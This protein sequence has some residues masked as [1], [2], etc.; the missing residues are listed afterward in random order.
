[1]LRNNSQIN[2]RAIFLLFLVYFLFQLPATAA[3]VPTGFTVSQ[4]A[5]GMTSVT[6]M[7]L[8]PDGRILVCEQSGKLRVIENGVLRSTPYLTIDADS[9]SEHG[10]LGITLDPGFETNQFFY[11]YYTAKTPNIHNR[12]SRFTAGA[13][14]ADPASE[15]VIFDID[16]STGPL[17]WHQGGNIGFGSDGKLYI[18]VG[19]DRNGANSQSFT[20]LFGKILRINKDGSIPSDNPFFATATGNYRAIWALGLRNPYTFAFNKFG[21]MFIN[22]VGEETWEEI[23]GGVRGGNYGWPE[24][25][26]V[27]SDQRFITPLLAYAHGFESNEVGCAITGGTFYEPSILQFPQEYSG[28]YFYADF[29]MGWIRTVRPNESGSQLFATF[30]YFPVDLKVAKNGTLY[31]LERGLDSSNT[32]GAVFKIEFTSQKAPVITQQPVNV[33]VAAGQTASFSVQASG[34]APLSYRWQRNGINLDGPSSDTPTL[35]ITAQLTDNGASYACV[36]TNQFGSVT[37]QAAQLTVVKG[38]AP[39]G[40][41]ALPVTGTQYRGGDVIQYSGTGTDADEGNLPASAFTW[42]VDFHHDTHTHPFIPAFSGTTSGQFTIPTSG[43]T[44]TDVWYRIHLTVKDSSGLTHTVFRDILPVVETV[45]LATNPAG[46]QIKLDDQPQATPKTISTVVG[47]TRTISAVSPQLLNGQLYEFDSWSDG[48]AATHTINHGGTF[49]ANFKPVVVSD[50]EVVLYASEGTRVGNYQVVSDATAAGG[51]RLHNPDAGAAKLSNAL[52]NPGTYVEMQFKAKAGVAYRLWI[53]GQ[54]QNNDPFSDSV[55]VQFNDSLDEQGTAKSR[56][57]TTGSEVINL[58]DCFGCGLNGW[59]WQDNGWGVG[60][61]GPL[62]YFSTSGT[63]TVRIQ[64][65]EDGLSLDQVVLSPE[66]YLNIAP[67]ALVNDTTILPKRSGSDGGPPPPPPPSGTDVVLYASEATR[68]G[69]YEVVNDATAAG[70]ARLH[71]P[72]TGAAKLSNAL[73]S[74]G[75]FVEMQFTA[76]AGVGYRLWIRGK[77]QNDDPFNDS[78]FVQFND[79]VDSQGGAKSRIGTTSSEVINLEDCFACGLSGWGWQDNGWGVGELGPLVFFATSGTHTLRIQPREDGLSLDQIVLSP[80][81]FVSTSPGAVVND[82]TILPKS[83]SGGPPPAPGDVVLYASEG[84]R[85][86]NYQVVSDATAAGGSRLH[87]PDGGAGKLSNALANPGTFVEM[88]FTAQAGVA[89]RLWIRGKAQNDD[90][91]NDSVFVQFNDSVDENG[92]A[93]SRIG[94]TSSEVINLEDCFACGLGGWGWQDNGWGVGELGPLVYFAAT[95]THTLRIQVR[96]DGLSI[97][98]IVLSP[99]TYLTTA[100]GAVTNDTTILTKT[101]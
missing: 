89:Y 93:K 88:Q 87:N 6:R 64:P 25:E 53:R 78:I 91:F 32:E 55:F 34:S 16:P 41:I 28:A 44:A 96:E 23:N 5:T 97:D 75:T 37:S 92:V 69:N 39:V 33:T 65:R 30:T 60:V 20:S 46:L 49:T 80:T 36:V 17:G 24:T 47:V 29:C 21:S 18:A 76:Q 68:T 31:Y 38:S 14:N 35:N 58:E 51:A 54:S 48:G 13:T 100:P 90:P 85:T 72:N 11:V 101:P 94:T 79:S 84:T 61:F 52:A 7:A 19:D 95:G 59:G 26:G 4:V 43:E 70:G 10:L 50:T 9:F 57:G 66:A 45:T 40:S 56:I 8:L 83:G 1:M 86:G 12:V 15:A 67:G 77:A 71:N 81:T 63:H 74:P 73:A 42:Q 62:V 27:T 98:Q 3:E 2:S 22:D 82:N 99:V